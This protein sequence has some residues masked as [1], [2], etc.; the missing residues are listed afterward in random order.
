MSS[1]YHL[2]KRKKKKFDK[3]VSTILQI[4]HC[5]NDNN[6]NVNRE[7][8]S[9]VHKSVNSI[10]NEYYVKASRPD[11]PKVQMEATLILKDNKPIQFRPRRLSLIEK[12]KVDYI[13]NNL[14]ERKIIRKSTLEYASP[15]VLTRK[16]TGD[17]RMCIDYRALNRVLAR[18]NYPLPFI[19]D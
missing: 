10:F 17:I 7:K 11:F 2:T 8:S 14:L 16:K 9:S 15:I 5:S 4:D 12:E 1:N 3:I 18:D 19:D 6:I 13:L